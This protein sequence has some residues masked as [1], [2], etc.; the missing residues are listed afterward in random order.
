MNRTM[1]RP[2][3]VAIDASSARRLTAAPYPP[4]RGG[5]DPWH[6]DG[7]FYGRRADDGSEALLLVRVSASRALAAA[8]LGSCPHVPGSLAPAPTRT[9]HLSRGPL[10]HWEFPRRGLPPST[11]CQEA[12]IARL[13]STVRPP[14]ACRVAPRSGG[15]T[16]PASRRC[17][18]TRRSLCG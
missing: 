7:A 2:L 8:A 13:R 17:P 4:V 6:Y 12:S 3:V 18:W 14:A 9:T 16:P 15:V 5:N 11:L 1:S 10:A